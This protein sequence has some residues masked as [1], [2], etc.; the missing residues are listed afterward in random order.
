MLV[1][2]NVSHNQSCSSYNVNNN[3]NN[4][5]NN[6]SLFKEKLISVYLPFKKTKPKKTFNSIWK[7]NSTLTKNINNKQHL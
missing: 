6:L 1:R 3:N 4:N 2:Y 5:N 7:E